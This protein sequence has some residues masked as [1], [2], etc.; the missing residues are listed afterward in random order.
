M[1]TYSLGFAGHGKACPIFPVKGLP[2]FYLLCSKGFPSLKRDHSML[3]FIRFEGI[4]RS[5]PEGRCVLCIYDLIGKE[6]LYPPSKRYNS[7]RLFLTDQ[8]G[9][10]EQKKED[11][12]SCLSGRV[13]PCRIS[14]REYTGLLSNKVIYAKYIRALWGT[15][16]NP[17]ISSLYTHPF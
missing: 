14:L 2:L 10:E 11:Q 1:E 6:L 15:S 3:N 8:R 16:P 5:F 7:G 13:G 17:L 4:R 12:K 9:G